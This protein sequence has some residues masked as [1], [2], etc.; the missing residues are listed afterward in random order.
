[1]PTYATHTDEELLQAI[2][3]DD[4]KAFAEL[5]QRY[6]RRTHI[7]AYTKVRSTE[8]TEEMV[9][10]FFMNL[11]DKRASLQIQ[12]FSSYLY[13]SIKNKALKFIES[14][15]VEKKYWEYYKAFVP[16]TEETTHAAVQ[17][18]ALLEAIEEG[19]QALP[20]KSKKVFQLSR[21]EGRSIPEIASLLNLSEKAIEYHLTR[22][23]KY[24]KVHLKDFIVVLVTAIFY[25]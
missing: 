11:W 12:N 18:N 10:E 19:M 8:A 13:T 1:M 20:Q 2:R 22:S 16:Q 14:R 3:Q 5:F 25:Q 21:L 23:L 7:L 17:Y 4:E 24:I 15:I 9:Q 6:W